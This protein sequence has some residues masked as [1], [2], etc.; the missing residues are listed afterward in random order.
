MADRGDRLKRTGFA[1]KVPARAPRAPLVPL[2]PAVTA[3]LRRSDGRARLSVA[4]PKR[5]IVRSVTL[6]AAYRLIPCQHCGKDDGTVCGAHSNW[7]Q[8]GK[9]KAQKA[10]D[11]RCASLCFLCHLLL[12]Q[13]AVLAKD[14]RKG[15]WWAAHIRTVSRL[16]AECLW[17][18]GVPVPNVDDNPFETEGD[19]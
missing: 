6:M 14:Q 11:N 15:M 3:A 13:G 9:G 4:I 19:L 10:D 17:P 16:Q 2:A 1:S 18:A 8:H 5:E 7:G 12:D